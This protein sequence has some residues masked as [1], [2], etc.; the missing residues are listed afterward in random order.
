MVKDLFYANSLKKFMTMT[1]QQQKLLKI[2]QDEVSQSNTDKVYY[3]SE[4]LGW[5]PFGVYH[6]LQ[7]GDKELKLDSVGT[8]NLL[9]DLKRLVTEKYL[10][11]IAYFQDEND[12]F[13]LHIDYKL[14]KI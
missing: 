8:N 13:E 14:N 3:R 1:L 5:L 10:T 9:E 7:V 12:E 2:I 6:W 4:W 11:Q